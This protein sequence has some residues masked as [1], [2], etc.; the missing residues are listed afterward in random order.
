MLNIKVSRTKL[1]G[2]IQIVE[3]AISENKI[4]PIISGIFMEAKGNI[5]TLKGTD[6]EMTITSAI[7]GEVI[8]EGRVVFSHKLLVEYLKEISDEIVQINEQ[9]GELKVITKY[10][11]SEFYVYDSDE[12]PMIK[13]LEY[14]SEYYINKNIFLNGLEKVSIATSNT[15]N[16]AVNCVRLEIE[17]K[18]IKMLGT[19]SYRL[20]YFEENLSTDTVSDKILKISIPLKT[21]DSLIKTLKSIEG[22][23]INLKFEGNQIFFV[24]GEVAILS[25][26]IDLAYPDY[27][28][29]LKNQEYNK[30]IF[31]KKDET[32]SLMKRV[33]LF[34]RNNK[35]GKNSGLFNFIGNKLY[36]KGISDKAK[37]NEE[38]DILKE[39]DDLKISLNVKFILDYILQVEEENIEFEM[40]N[41]SSG[42]LIKG[43]GNNKFIYLTMPLA[44]RED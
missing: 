30:K 17:D 7:E 22:D 14:G 31:M 40:S 8:E 44:L 12:Y 24:I 39:G 10:S 3:R 18:K 6:L 41:A 42:V 15:E 32:I 29:I 1:L 4:R 27:A 26:I 23:V 38:L 36:I 34:V 9:D 43:E 25:R 5:I 21:V 19:D 35:E 28:N 2:V 11:E 37:V 20:A 16:L 13:S 33:I